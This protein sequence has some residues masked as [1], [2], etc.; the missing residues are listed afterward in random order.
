[1]TR[2]MTR[3]DATPGGRPCGAFRPNDARIEQVASTGDTSPAMAARG[4]RMRLPRFPLVAQ[5]DVTLCHLS[6]P[7]VACASVPPM[8]QFRIIA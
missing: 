4:G 1:M 8:T 6:F 3:F 2:P 7:P 5:R